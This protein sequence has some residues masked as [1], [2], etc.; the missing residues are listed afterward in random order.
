MLSALQIWCRAWSLVRIDN[1]ESKPPRKLSNDRRERETERDASFVMA[2][3]A[4]RYGR[5][6]LRHVHIL[7]MPLIKKL[8]NR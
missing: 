1:S 4:K 6:Q 3:K 7:R 5:N 8:L 2:V